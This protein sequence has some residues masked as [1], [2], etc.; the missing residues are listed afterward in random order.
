MNYR[1]IYG[2]IIRN[3]I[4]ENRTKSNDVYYERHHILPKSLGGSDRKSNLVLLTAKEHYICHLL[5]VKI[6]RFDEKKRKTAMKA[7]LMMKPFYFHKNRNFNSY[8]F[9]KIKNTLYGE[10]GLSRGAN[11]HRYGKKHSLE[12]KQKISEKQKIVANTKE[13]KD[14]RK[15][16]AK[17]K[18]KEEREFIRNKILGQK[19]TDEQKKKM[20]ES[21]KGLQLNEKNGKS[22]KVSI[23]GVIYPSVREYIR[24]NGKIKNLYNKINDENYTSFFYVM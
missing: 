23:N 24:Q 6:F 15:K 11:H 10:G 2:N 14:R 21:H 17:N 22:K 3:S 19:R 13:S 16:L 1:K 4:S 12:T 9:T 7:V 20:S 5:L 8:H 18:S